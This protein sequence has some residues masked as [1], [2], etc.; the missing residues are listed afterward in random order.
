[1][2]CKLCKAYREQFPLNKDGK[3]ELG[4]HIFSDAIECAFEYGYEFSTGNWNCQ[5]MVALRELTGADESKEQHGTWLAHD[6]G[7]YAMLPIP[8]DSFYNPVLQDGAIVMSWYKA[9]GRTGRALV[10]QDD[11]FPV[12]LTRDTAEFVLKA[13]AEKGKQCDSSSQ[14]SADTSG[15]RS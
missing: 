11:N 3:H 12:P 15:P 7:R 9:R 2:T 5:T 10:L 14:S 13:Y 6:D 8:S 1:M 4:N